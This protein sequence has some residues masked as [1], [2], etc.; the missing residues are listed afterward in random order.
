MPIARP[1]LGILLAAALL[2]AAPA[3]ARADDA[4][5]Q[6]RQLVEQAN[7]DYKL[8]RFQEALDGYSRAY[9][10]FHAP[11]LLFNIGQCHR[12]L[13]HHERAIFFFAG[14]LREKP[15]DPNRA[16]VESLIGESRAALAA[17]RAEEE[18]RRREAEDRAR[19][20]AGAPAPAE[21]GPP[22]Y[23]KWWFW[24]AVGGAALVAGGSLY[25]FSGE[26][27]DPMG[28]LGLIDGRGGR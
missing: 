10:L 24:T 22:I 11:A 5:D 12:N 2:A 18:R 19:L 9:E 28:S 27:T 13:G 14:F 15:D 3:P 7:T 20:L 6:A 26:T 4:R 21:P 1:S 8:G 25:Y 23:R 17:E 16:L